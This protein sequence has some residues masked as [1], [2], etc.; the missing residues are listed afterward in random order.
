MAIGVQSLPTFADRALAGKYF[1]ILAGLA[2]SIHDEPW[3]ESDGSAFV[4]PSFL[5]HLKSVVT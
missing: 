2:A 5:Q 1:P 3:I 4:D